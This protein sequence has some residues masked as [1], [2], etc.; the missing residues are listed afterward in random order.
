MLDFEDD[1]RAGLAFCGVTKGAESS[2]ERIA[3][4]N[5]PR[6]DVKSTWLILQ[7]LI[8]KQFPRACAHAVGDAVSCEVQCAHRRAS[9]GISILHSG[10]FLVVGSAG[11]SLRDRSINAL[12]GFTTK[13]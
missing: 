10:H 12:I 6:E 2:N 7:E 4:E 3:I 9:I 11:G 1:C 5:W 13:K 8:P